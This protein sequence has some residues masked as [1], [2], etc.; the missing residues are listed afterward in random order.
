MAK[1]ILLILGHPSENSFNN[2][3][4]DAYKKGAESAGAICKTGRQFK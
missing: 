1:N 3:L 2:A 4:L